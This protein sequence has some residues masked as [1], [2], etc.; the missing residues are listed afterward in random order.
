M[1]RY[2]DSAL[3]YIPNVVPTAPLIT[4]GKLP[5]FF[6]QSSSGVEV[7]GL[8]TSTVS[9]VFLPLHP[10]MMRMY[11]RNKKNRVD[12]ILYYPVKKGEQ[13]SMKSNLFT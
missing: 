5:K 10:P 6:M 11:S 13:Y 2:S 7:S 1:I 4:V 9:N 8:T 12:Y 3:L